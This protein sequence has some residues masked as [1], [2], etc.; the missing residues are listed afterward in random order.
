M[1]ISL[2]PVFANTYMRVFGNKSLKPIIYCMYVNDIFI[3]PSNLQLSTTL[4][5]N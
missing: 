4:T 5:T 3:I 1:G 2:I